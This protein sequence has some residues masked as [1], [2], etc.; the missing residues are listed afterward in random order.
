[1][2]SSVAT[3]PWGFPN[4]DL[5]VGYTEVLRYIQYRLKVLGH[6]QL[7]AFC[8]QFKFSYNTVVNLKNGT[9]KRKEYLQLQKILSALSFD[10]T[11]SLNP[12]A[13]SEENKYLYLFAGIEELNKFKEQ[14]A[15]IDQITPPS[16]R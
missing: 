8:N 5:S 3:A 16:S 10:T 7:K 13:T 11:A 9:S 4:P 14:L 12:L 2:S 15:Y 1:M 6:G